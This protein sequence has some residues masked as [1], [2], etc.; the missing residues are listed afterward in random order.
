MDD[1]Q[2][3]LSGKNV[4]FLIGSGAS[5]PMYPT[6]S[7]GD[8]CRS[9]E[10]LLT[11]QNIS[12][13]V[14]DLLYC[15]YYYRW[16]QPM[17]KGKLENN[18]SVSDNYNAFVNILIN[19]LETESNEQP[20]RVN[21]FTTNYDLN[22]EK[23]LDRIA[24]ERYIF[25]NDG[26]SGFVERRLK[27]NNFYMTVHHSGY[28]DFY[29]HEIPCVNLLKLHGSLSWKRGENGEILLDY[30][31][32][33]HDLDKPMK[34]SGR[35]D[36]LDLLN[37]QF[38]SINS[39]LENK[40]LTEQGLLSNHLGKLDDEANLE[41]VSRRAENVKALPIINPDKWKF[42]DTVF[43]QHYYQMIRSFSYE[44]EK[45]NS[46]LIIFGFS[47]S[48]EHLLDIFKR[49][50]T[51]PT[52]Y[53]IVFAFDEAAKNE[54]KQKI[55]ESNKV[56]FYPPSFKTDDGKDLSGDFQYMNKVLEG[57]TK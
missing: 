5:V 51:N 29:R 14:K 34:L 41:I 7:M 37:Q 2:E 46:V 17:I 19:F 39:E 26:G 45:K 25:V 15:F 33:S 3:I 57:K 55:G 52:L 50:M 40:T 10:E 47:F 16:I 24:L 54:L 6:L 12:D 53:V 22:F 43:E 30:L 48:D 31:A 13:G 20:K 44:L 32:E 42:H 56:I 8:N 11:D 9:L 23:C 27:S 38:A 49:S 35:T 36:F 4:N 1:L 18:E 21:I 28:T